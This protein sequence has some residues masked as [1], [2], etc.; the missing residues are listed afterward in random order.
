M[1]SGR[2]ANRRRTPHVD[3]LTLEG[4]LAIEDLYSLVPGVGRV[5]V[6]LRIEGDPAQRVELAVRRSPCAPRLDEFAVLVKP[7]D[8]GIPVAIGYIDVPGGIP[9]DVGRPLKNVALS[10]RTS[11]STAPSCRWSL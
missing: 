2:D 4:S 10:A 11:G 8:A 5:D 1:R 9:G 6:A 3:D 7:G